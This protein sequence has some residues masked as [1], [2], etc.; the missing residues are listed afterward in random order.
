MQT[1]TQRRTFII[2]AAL[3]AGSLGCAG[4]SR[5]AVKKID[6]S[7]PK[8]KSLGYRNDTTQVDRARFPK[9]SPSEKCNGCM[10]WLGTKSDA[11]AECDLLPD[12]SVAAV[13]WC[14]SYVKVK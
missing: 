12:R 5:A 8:A 6:E 1:P 2:Q 7:E 9:H 11:W 4:V 10:A 3:A 14:S 13:G